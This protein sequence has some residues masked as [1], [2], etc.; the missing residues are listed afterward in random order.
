MVIYLVIY[1]VR[2]PRQ[3]IPQR[4]LGL[5][6]LVHEKAHPV[7]LIHDSL[8]L[9]AFRIQQVPSTNHPIREKVPGYIPSAS[10][11]LKF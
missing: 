2:P 9:K 1:L 10:S 4:G 3:D 7:F 6:G 11:F 8:F 5:G